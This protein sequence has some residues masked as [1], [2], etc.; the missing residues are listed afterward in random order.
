MAGGFQIPPDQLRAHAGR[1]D[2]HA[3]ALGQTADA[4]RSVQ[5]DTDAYGLICQFLPPALNTASDIV[6]QSTSAA[7]DA[8]AAL[9]TSLRDAVADHEATDA[10][11]AVA[12]DR[13]ADELGG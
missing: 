11:I 6:L 13:I 2:S 9:S 5:L 4:G 12:L 7:H 3:A 10:E 8:I 1:L